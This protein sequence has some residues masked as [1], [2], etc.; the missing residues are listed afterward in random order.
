M[1][2]YYIKANKIETLESKHGFEKIQD[3]RRDLKLYESEKD[4]PVPDGYEIKKGEIVPT[5]ETLKFNERQE[6]LNRLEDLDKK[7]IRGLRAS[8]ASTATQEDLDY[9]SEIEKEA[10]K[11]RSFLN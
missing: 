7:S 9:L 2:Y 1:N 3:L 4:V 5:K 8:L 11:V 6:L 10:A